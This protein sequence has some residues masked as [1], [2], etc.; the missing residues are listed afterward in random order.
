MEKN[1]SFPNCNCAFLPSRS[2]NN[3]IIIYQKELCVN[4]IHF[5]PRVCACVRMKRF[6]VIFFLFQ[7]ISAVSQ[8]SLWNGTC[9]CVCVCACVQKIEQPQILLLPHTTYHPANQ[10]T[11]QQ[12]V[13]Q[14]I[15]YSCIRSKKKKTIHI[16][17]HNAHNTRTPTT[18]AANQPLVITANVLNNKLVSRSS[19]W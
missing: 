14:D 19:Y 8:V 17:T 15:S 13:I 5:C 2:S 16:T 10:P 12:R 18:L 9:M 1:H 3:C 6:C 11:N 4:N 7:R